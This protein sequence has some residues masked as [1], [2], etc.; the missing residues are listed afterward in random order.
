GGDGNG[1]RNGRVNGNG[2]RGG[3]DN[4]NNNGNGGGNGYENHNVNFGGFMPVARECT[5]QDFLKCQPFNFKGAEGV[6]GLT[7]WFGM[8]ETLFHISNYAK[9]QPMKANKQTQPQLL[10]PYRTPGN[11]LLVEVTPA[12]PNL[13][14]CL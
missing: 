2:K 12:A 9:P 1:N 11:P 7:R 8:M 5:Y 6:F 10:T 4:G 3:N 13:T 14:L